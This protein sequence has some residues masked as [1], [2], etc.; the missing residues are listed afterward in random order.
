M[1]LWHLW[2][3]GARHPWPGSA[4]FLLRFL[5]LGRWLTHGDFALDAEV[6]FVAVVEHRLIPARVR[7]EWSRLRCKRLASILGAC[8]AGCV[9]CRSCWCWG[10]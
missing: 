9:A 10:C 4:P 5:M 7:S 3:G 6:D 1:V 8:F 2:I